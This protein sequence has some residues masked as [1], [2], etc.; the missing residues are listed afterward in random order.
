[1]LTPEAVFF[2]PDNR[3]VLKTDTEEKTWTGEWFQEMTAAVSWAD[4]NEARPVRELFTA[5]LLQELAVWPYNAVIFSNYYTEAG[6]FVHLYT[7]D[8]PDT[9]DGTDL[10]TDPESP[11]Q[12]GSGVVTLCTGSAAPVSET[13]PS[14]LGTAVPDPGTVRIYGLVF[15]DHDGDSLYAPGEELANE[16]V[17]I[18]PL[19]GNPGTTSD[20]GSGSSASEPVYQVTTDNAGYFSVSLDP[21]QYWVFETWKQEQVSRRIIYIDTDRFVKMSFFPPDLL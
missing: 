5:L 12:S 14:G 3:L 1:M 16:T 7:D 15:L 21:G 6:P 13:D 2:G 9:G 17:D 19:A 8:S 10:E 20:D 11:T 18:Y 4:M